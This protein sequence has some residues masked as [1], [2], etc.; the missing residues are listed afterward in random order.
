METS[1]ALF[2]NVDPEG[3]KQID[4]AAAGDVEAFTSP[5]APGAQEP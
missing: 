4:V 5:F 3:E 1:Q 2:G